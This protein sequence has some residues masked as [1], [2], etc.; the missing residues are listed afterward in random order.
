MS[1][2][3]RRERVR[4][5][6]SHQPP[7]RVPC[8]LGGR[9]SN[10]HYLAYQR[11][12]ETLD[13]PQHELE[14]DPF[15]SV[16]NLSPELLERLGVDFQYLFLRGPEYV[17]KRTFRDGS[18]EN[19]WGVRVERVG[20]HSQRVTHPLAQA[21][22][23]DLAAYPWPQADA[24]RRTEGLAER[25]C[26]LFD[27][28]DYALVAAPVSGG[29]F[30]YG[31]HLRGMAQ[32]FVD[33][34]SDKPFA[35][36][37]LDHLL[38]VQLELWD[39][40]LTVVGE[41]VDMVQLADDFGSQRSLLISPRLFREMFKPRYA[42]LIRFIKERTAARVFFHCDGAI[43]PLLDD[44]AEMGVDVLNPL[45]PTATGMEPGVI[46]QRYGGR[47][48][49]HGGI[50]NQQLLPNGRPDEVR[51]AV[52]DAIGALAAGGGYVVASA[53]VIEPDIPNQNVLALFEAVTGS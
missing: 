39:V 12:L 17:S 6:L 8:D 45:Q 10:I 52:H 35:N 40:F 15:F 19:E 2:L 46:K 28:T 43:L 53:H 25:S 41:R 26:R 36:S 44:F 5:A 49:F 22:V 51:S 3:A 30:E 29:I 14:L 21:D 47:L 27:E 11:L 18:Y 50:D 32:F 1:E 38:A 13:L 23:A 31:Q 20:I 7:D 33:L 24:A 42:Q 34:M 9:V 4:L 37:L 16:M 48:A